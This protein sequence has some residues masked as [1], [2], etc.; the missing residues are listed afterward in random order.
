[1]REIASIEIHALV[2]ELKPKIVGGFLRKFYDLGN[3]SFRLGFYKDGNQVPVYCK[4]LHT[5][6]ET[7][8]SESAG[9]P[10]QFAL[11]VR[12]RVEGGK[13][14]S[15][16][17]HGTDR[18]IVIEILSAGNVQ[19]L[20]IEMFGKG[21]VILANREL[22]IEQCYSQMSFKDRELKPNSKYL[23]PRS[24][25]IGVWDAEIGEIAESIKAVKGKPKPIPE[26]L[27]YIDI[28]PL[29]MENAFSQAGIDTKA[30]L[31]GDEDALRLAEAIHS[32]VAEVNSRP[33]PRIY[34][35]NGKAIDF[36]LCPIAKY[37]KDGYEKS[38]YRSISQMFDSLYR[39]ERE[40]V[41]EELRA[42]KLEELSASIKKQEE[43]AASH[44]AEAEE[45]QKAGNI[46]FA[47]MHELNELIEYMGRN[48]KATYEEVRE[49][50]KE[51][52][53]KGLDLKE[54]KVTLEL[55]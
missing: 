22:V 11:G 12:K 42:K 31:K 2:N 3:K 8:L 39:I 25:A 14:L 27:K 19:N 45:F 53:I 21:N 23:F 9:E 41:H 51:L 29:Y 37:E 36:A 24:Q 17:Q 5:L 6:N 35:M 38:G 33:S 48:K 30:A 28:G 54:K 32:M 18:V 10:S 34:S 4:L 15:F 55:E 16:E 40:T 44:R 1:M 46:I 26:A 7:E 49:R 47:H 13:I 52:K 43:L 50:F 20:I